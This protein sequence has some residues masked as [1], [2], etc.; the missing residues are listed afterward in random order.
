MHGP[1]MGDMGAWAQEAGASGSK[2]E[3]AREESGPAVCL[4]LRRLALLHTP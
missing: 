4:H 2:G 1:G 3:G